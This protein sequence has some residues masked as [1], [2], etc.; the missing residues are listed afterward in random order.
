MGRVPNFGSVG[1][2]GDLTKT[3]P[4]VGL[5]LAARQQMV[6]S[7][8]L[9][10]VA[11]ILLVAFSVRTSR[12][13]FKELRS[14]SAKTDAGRADYVLGLV[15]IVAGMAGFG[16]LVSLRSDYCGVPDSNHLYRCF[17][18]GIVP[19]LV[20]TYLKNMGIEVPSLKPLLDRSIDVVNISVVA[21]AACLL[22][23]L[24]LLPRGFDRVV[25]SGGVR[26]PEKIGAAEL[27]RWLD[28][29]VRS[30]NGLSLFSALVFVA[31]IAQ[32]FAWMNWP[33]SIMTKGLITGVDEDIL[34]ESYQALINGVLQFHA[35][36]FGMLVA[37]LIFTTNMVLFF[38][39][40]VLAREIIAR[41]TASIAAAEQQLAEAA[42]A[43]QAAKA[44][45]AAKAEIAAA[46]ETMTQAN[47]E[48]TFKSY[49]DSYRGYLLALAP[50]IVQ[51]LLTLGS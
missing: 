23:T 28:N 16:L 17:G 42:T 25:V 38:K 21:A 18:Q 51:Q 47:D 11:A 31:G 35:V 33:V 44:I 1:I 40:R 20:V 13:I 9:V 34:R 32:M 50:A 29:R 2:I 10:L 39:C 45:E 6:T 37:A 27:K 43:E 8:F 4:A 24:L 3:L 7:T 5:E 15:V 22:F 26:T 49:F 30:L 36:W 19:D 12:A 41:C 48:A 14:A 46:E